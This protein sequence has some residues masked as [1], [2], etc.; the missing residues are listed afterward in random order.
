MHPRFALVPAS[1]W[2]FAVALPAQHTASR[3]ET[4]SVHPAPAPATDA[5]ARPNRQATRTD[6]DGMRGEFQRGHAAFLGLSQRYRPMAELRAQ[7]LPHAQVGDSPGS[8]A[9]TSLRAQADVPVSVSADSMFTLGG[10]I[11]DRHYLANG[12]GGFG[13]ESLW[14]AAV[15]ASFATFLNPDLLLETRIEPGLWSDWQGAIGKDDLDGPIS[16]VAT[17]RTAETFF[18]RF[19]VRYNEVYPRHSILPYGGFSWRPTAAVR[20]D[21][22]A[23]E[24]VELSYWPQPDFGLLLG[25][26]V[27]GAEYHVRAPLGIRSGDVRIQEVLVYTGAIWRQSA[28]TSIAARLGLTA[29]GDY[30]LDDNPTEKVDGTLQPGLFLELSFGFD[31]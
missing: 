6:E 18:L 29:A 24:Q 3:L 30:R 22:L 4:D 7:F 23:P 28:T 19:G 15:R 9:M 25:A 5:A 13:D 27:Q 8:F 12:L 1:C 20:V 31:F 10:E 21:V 26:E 2:L 16:V 11:E 14:I 17:D